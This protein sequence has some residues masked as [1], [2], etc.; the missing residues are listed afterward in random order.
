MFK[1]TLAVNLPTKKRGFFGLAPFFR[2]S[3][4]YTKLLS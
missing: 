1:E 4:R 3:F 2:L